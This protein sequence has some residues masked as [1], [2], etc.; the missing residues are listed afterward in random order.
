MASSKAMKKE[1]QVK[2]VTCCGQGLFKASDYNYRC[3]NTDHSNKPPY[4]IFAFENGDD[5]ELKEH[6][7]SVCKERKQKLT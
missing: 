1:E 5:P 2:G 3:A 7:V 6:D 4:R